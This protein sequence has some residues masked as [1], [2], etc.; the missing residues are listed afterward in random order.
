MHRVWILAAALVVMARS[1][2]ADDVLVWRGDRS[3]CLA[4]RADLDDLSLPEST[5]EV[6]P[7][8]D[9]VHAGWAALDAGCGRSRLAIR[10]DIYAAE[11]IISLPLRIRLAD[12]WTAYTL[13]SVTTA[14]GASEV[15]NTPSALSRR[16]RA[17][18]PWGMLTT[19]D[20]AALAPTSTVAADRAIGLGIGAAIVAG[21]FGI[22][23]F[24]VHATT[25]VEVARTLQSGRV[26]GG[27]VA[28]IGA[29]IFPLEPAT[30]VVDLGQRIDRDG[31]H[32]WGTFGV[33]VLVTHG[34][35]FELAGTR[36]R[37]ATSGWFSLYLLRG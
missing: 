9:P 32:V 34:V 22:S 24:S 4:S 11:T 1:A 3:T 10:A 14:G 2:R 17:L 25:A 37:S 30:F 8:R 18:S 29:E 15:G 27:G 31:Y 12:D 23:A 6:G 16:V 21:T 5:Y 20:V 7:M 33:R 13:P 28:L 35:G 19:F 26:D 36:D